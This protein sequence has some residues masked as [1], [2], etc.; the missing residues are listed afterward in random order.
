MT[1]TLTLAIFF[2]KLLCNSSEKVEV[3]VRTSRWQV[4]E[5]NLKTDSLNKRK[6]QNAGFSSHS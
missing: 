3:K 5:L 2:S 6:K 4:F 1:G